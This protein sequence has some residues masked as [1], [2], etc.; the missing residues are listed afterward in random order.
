MALETHP[1]RTIK[2]WAQMLP[3]GRAHMA[4]HAPRSECSRRCHRRAAAN[5]HIEDPPASIG[6]LNEP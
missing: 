5:M 2:K 3:K 1:L 6:G 4:N